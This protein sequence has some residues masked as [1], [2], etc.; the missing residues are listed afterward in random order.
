M[1]EN[2]EKEKDLV[3][4]ARLALAGRPQD[5]Q[6]YVTRIS[7]KYQKLAPD[8][9]DRLKDLMKLAPTRQSPLRSDGVATIPVDRD[10][11]LQLL[12][13]EPQ[14]TLNHEPIWTAAI[15]EQ[16]NQIVSEHKRSN[17]LLSSG[18]APTRT[19]IFTGPPGVGKTMAA[20]WLATQLDRPLLILDL[21]AVMSSFLGRT[22]SNVRHVLDYAK[23]VSCVLLLD[24]LDAIAKRRDDSQEVGELKRLVTVLLQ[25]IDDWPE[26]GLLIAASNHQELLDPAVWRR[27]EMQIQFALPQLSAVE[28]AIRLFVDDKAVL[29]DV[30]ATALAELLLGHSFSDIERELKNLRRQAVLSNCSL[31]ELF[32]K[33]VRQH[34]DD[35]SKSGKKDIALKLSGA[36]M[37]QRTVNELTGISRDTLRKMNRN[38]EPQSDQS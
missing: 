8:L 27:F 14:G 19:A 2:K 35:Q 15:A 25:E 7:R 28:Q 31:E 30:W 36:G 21:S 24:E 10:S 32:P 29:K 38:G 34:I 17:E 5:I 20:R 18:L 9:G 6:T 3:Q 33:L 16:L 1:D 13:H 23:G 22:G 26:G 37:S 4:L 11:R 12:R